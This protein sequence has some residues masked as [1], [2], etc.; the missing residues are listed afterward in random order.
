MKMETRELELYLHIPFCARKC[1]YCDF[2]SF[3]ADLTAMTDVTES[4]NFYV[5]TGVTASSNLATKVDDSATTNRSEVAGVTESANLAA[6]TDDSTSANCSEVADVSG[7][8]NLAASV[9][10]SASTGTSAPVNRCTIESYLGALENEL[11]IRSNE[12][13]AYPIVSIFIGGGTPSLLSGK[14]IASL[15]DIIRDNYRLGTPSTPEIEITIEANPD[16]LTAKKA[17]AYQAAGINRISI[18]LQS[19]NDAEL[20]RLGRIHTFSQFLTA[21]QAARA[22]GFT[23][24]NVDLMSALPGQ[25]RE[26][27][28]QTL[29]AVLSLTPPPEHISAYS[30]I[31]EEQTPFWEMY[32]KGELEFPTEDLDRRM[33]DDTKHILQQNGY[34]RYEIS[35]YA[36]PGYECRHNCGY[37]TRRNYAGFGL[38]AASL[39][40]N[41]R[42]SNITDL[43]EYIKYWSNVVTAP[44]KNQMPFTIDHGISNHQQ[45]SSTPFL[46]KQSLTV[47]EQMEEF[48][49]LGLRLTQG[50]SPDVFFSQFG[51]PIETIYGQVIQSNIDSGLLTK[52]IADLGYSMANA[53]STK[54]RSPSIRLTEKGL[55]LSNYVMSQFL[56]DSY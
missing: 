41:T 53:S 10:A 14:A 32:Q 6:K 39:I 52:S 56:F 50:I 29:S 26:D 44:A 24:I 21:Y 42:F 8:A 35:N 23:N 17:V 18:G 31:V 37:W 9:A 5:A 49:F 54:D 47:K 20:E 4:A 3:P 38:G 30:L 45:A 12:Y 55:D 11:R 36:K 16:S 13:G 33:Y 28:L 25:T 27:Y 40:N 22:A 1:K 46:Y 15:M 19:A 34:Y 2:L 48:M 7:S 51:I 43:Q